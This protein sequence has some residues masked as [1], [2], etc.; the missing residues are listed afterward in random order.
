MQSTTLACSLLPK[1]NPAKLGSGAEDILGR[2]VR[3]SD[4]WWLELA[5]RE[6]CMKQLHCPAEILREL[7]YP[8][9]A[10]FSGAFNSILGNLK[11]VNIEDGVERLRRREPVPIYKMDLLETDHLSWDQPLTYPS[12]INRGVASEDA[13]KLVDLIL[14]RCNFG[15]FS[16]RNAFVRHMRRQIEGGILHLNELVARVNDEFMRRRSDLR[17]SLRSRKVQSKSNAVCA[18]GVLYREVEFSLTDKNS[19]PVDFIQVSGPSV[20]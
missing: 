12:Q 3:G 9:P 6:E 18:A 11:S 15:T 17:L 7:Q 4:S 14:L 19:S 20:G 16:E 10:V 13:R 5:C 8:S 1:W 2:S